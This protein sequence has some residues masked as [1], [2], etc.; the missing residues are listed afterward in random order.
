MWVEVVGI[1]SDDIIEFL[2]NNYD[3]NHIGIHIPTFLPCEY[4]QCKIYISIKDLFSWE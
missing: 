3:S 2:H 1:N 4:N